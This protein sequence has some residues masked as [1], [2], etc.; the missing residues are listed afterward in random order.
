MSFI[1]CVHS[2]EEGYMRHTRERKRTVADVLCS[3]SRRFVVASFLMTRVLQNFC[4]TYL[5]KHLMLASPGACVAG[6]LH[7]S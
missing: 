6:R 2:C 5:T 1:R 7:V 4:P 3:A